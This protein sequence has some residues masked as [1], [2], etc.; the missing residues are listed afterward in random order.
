MARPTKTGLDYFALDVCFTDTDDCID[1]LEAE[2]GLVGFAMLIK[3][4]QKIYANGYYICW[5]DDAVMLFARKVNETTNKVSSVINSA[6]RRKIFD[7]SAYK[8]FGVLTSRGIQRRYITTCAAAKRKHIII[9]R[10]YLLVT[11]EKI[12]GLIT[13]IT[14]LPSVEN[15]QS[16]VNQKVNLPIFNNQ[17]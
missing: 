12:L 4:W 9:D 13:E 16:K 11:D 10:R 15:T 1:L 2:H 17:V 8:N 14:D 5:N 3:L 6:F 7:R